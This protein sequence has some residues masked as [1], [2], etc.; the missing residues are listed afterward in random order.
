MLQLAGG[1]SPNTRTPCI[2]VVPQLCQGVLALQCRAPLGE[3]CK[4]HATSLGWR[5]AA[6]SLLW[7]CMPHLVNLV[8]DVLPTHAVGQAMSA[9]DAFKEAG[10]W[11]VVDSCNQLHLDGFKSP[12]VWAGD[13][14]MHALVAGICPHHLANLAAVHQPYAA[15]ISPHVC[16]SQLGSD[17]AACTVAAACCRWAY[18]CW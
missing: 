6:Y 1:W 18:R 15:C 12:L 10:P 9:G 14:C 7:G 3:L 4:A 2:G 13:D 5:Y 16:H 17:S 8:C 11:V